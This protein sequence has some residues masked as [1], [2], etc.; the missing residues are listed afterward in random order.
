M[1]YVFF[2]YAGKEKGKFY[3]S[4]YKVF[5]PHQ[6]FGGQIAW[7]YFRLNENIEGMNALCFITSY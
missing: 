1:Y 3:Y 7:F 2:I 4:S 6:E 5:S